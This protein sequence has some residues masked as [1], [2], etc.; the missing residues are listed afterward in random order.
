MAVGCMNRC[1]VALLICG[2]LLSAIIAQREI[3]GDSPFIG[4]KCERPSVAGLALSFDDTIYLPTWYESRPIFKEHGIK[5]TFFLNGVE[6]FNESQ[7][8]MVDHL[9]EDGHEIGYHGTNHTSAL[10]SLA[11]NGDAV[12]YRITEVDRGLSLMKERGY[13][14]DS[15]AYPFGARSI[16]TDEPLKDNFSVL[17]EVGGNKPGSNHWLAKCEDGG[18]FGAISL[19]TKHG[20]AN[21]VENT[22]DDAKMNDATL[23][24]YAHGIDEGGYHCNS[25]DLIAIAEEAEA[26]G[27]PFLTMSEL[28]R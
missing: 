10:E 3:T 7:W 23:V 17:R 22:V 13:V 20:N 26:N 1:A 19:D 12:T 9:V 6:R 18:V 16:E 11:E 15:F 8:E 28:G 25:E 27:L 5:A 14:V 4:E 2:I 24:L 21:W